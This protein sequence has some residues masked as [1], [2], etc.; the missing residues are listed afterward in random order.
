MGFSFLGNGVEEL[1]HI[2]NLKWVGGLSLEDA[3]ILAMYGRKCPSVLEY[4]SGGSTLIFAQTSKN[5]ISIEG[6]QRWIDAVQRRLDMIG[7]ATCP[8]EFVHYEGRKLVADSNE[9]VDLVFIDGVFGKRLQVALECWPLVKPGGYLMFHD[10]NRLTDSQLLHDFCI[11]NYTSIDYVQYNLV[12]SNGECSQISAVKKR[13]RPT[14]L[15]KNNW[16]NFQSKNMERELWT[17]GRFEDYDELQGL[18][19]Y[20]GLPEEVLDENNK[21]K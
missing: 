8:V 5:V 6:D 21:S 17:F 2:K 4:G 14:I 3:D 18:Y 12:A 15:L 9:K 13:P 11:N 1:E 19:V 7:E 16:S 10:T 20:R